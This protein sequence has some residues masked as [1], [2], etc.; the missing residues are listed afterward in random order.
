[1]PGELREMAIKFQSMQDR[2]RD[3]GSGRHGFGNRDHG[4]SSSHSRTDDHH[5]YNRDKRFLNNFGM[6]F[7]TH[8][9]CLRIFITISIDL[10]SRMIIFKLRKRKAVYSKTRM[11]LIFHIQ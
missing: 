2:K 8:F 7:N 10:Y 5:G 4:L 6:H 9:Y 3:Y 1:V 11:I